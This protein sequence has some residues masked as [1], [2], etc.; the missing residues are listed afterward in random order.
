MEN[1]IMEVLQTL[2]SKIGEMD[3]KIDTMQ[4]DIVS[5]KQG[6]SEIK[7]TIENDVN[8]RIDGL[9]DGY[10]LT[11]EKQWALERK[12]EQLERRLEKLENVS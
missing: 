12:M 11:H 2:V 4:K 9:F 5:L 1:E 3:N 10:Q 6:Q 7:T 8:K